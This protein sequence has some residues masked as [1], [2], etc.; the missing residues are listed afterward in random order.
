MPMISFRDVINARQ[1]VDDADVVERARGSVALQIALKATRP[2]NWWGSGIPGE[3]LIDISVRDG[4]PL[5]WVPSREVVVAVHAAPDQPSRRQLLVETA[6][7]VIESC[8]AAVDDCRDPWLSKQK[9]LAVDALHAWTSEAELAAM[10]LAVTLGESLM[11]KI[12]RPYILAF[13]SEDGDRKWYD[14]L[15]QRNRYRR[16]IYEADSTNPHI[17]HSPLERAVRA[18]ISHF[19]TT[20]YPDSG[21]PKPDLLSRHVAVHD[22]TTDHY[23]RGNALLAVMLMASLLYDLNDRYEAIRSDEVFEEEG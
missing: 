8:V 11:L 18:P 10:A 7:D 17:L 9:P 22:P 6:S 5:A 2:S 14:E 21:D 4:I 13:T 16:A 23:T 20:W 15:P 12:A 1:H 19:F 3:E